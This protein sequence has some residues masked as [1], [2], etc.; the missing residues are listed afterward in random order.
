M[1]GPGMRTTASGLA[2]AAARTAYGQFFD[3]IDPEDKTP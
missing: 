2:E 1:N 3:P